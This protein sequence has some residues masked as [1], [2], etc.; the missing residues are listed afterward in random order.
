MNSEA[1]WWR[2][3][4]GEER[5]GGRMCPVGRERAVVNGRPSGSAWIIYKRSLLRCTIGGWVGRGVC[6]C[7]WGLFQTKG[8]ACLLWI[9]LLL[10]PTLPCAYA[11]FSSALALSDQSNRW[12]EAVIDGVT[13]ASLKKKK[14]VRSESTEMRFIVATLIFLQPGT[15]R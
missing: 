9:P 1:G 13:C 8:T 3:P 12:H 6:V 5:S 4:I 14:K 7:V 10:C 2:R 15:S 11:T